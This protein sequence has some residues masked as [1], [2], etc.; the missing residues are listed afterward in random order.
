MVGLHKEREGER[1]F[2]ES[3]MAPTKDQKRKVSWKITFL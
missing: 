1:E 3:E 2:V